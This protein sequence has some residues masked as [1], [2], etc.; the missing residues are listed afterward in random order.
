MKSKLPRGGDARL[1][2]ALTYSVM[3]VVRAVSVVFLGVHWGP[4]QAFAAKSALLRKQSKA[5]QTG[6]AASRR[7]NPRR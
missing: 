7:Q 5:E 2:G 4:L 6:I 3:T 1:P